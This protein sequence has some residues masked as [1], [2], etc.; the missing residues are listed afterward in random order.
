MSDAAP[1]AS[2]DVPD[3]DAPSV[4][5][6]GLHAGPREETVARN[7]RRFYAGLAL[8]LTLHSLMFAGFYSSPPRFIGDPSG[9]PDAISV[10]LVTDAEL[11]DLAATPD[12][13]PQGSPIPPVPTPQPPAEAT[14]PPA[15]VTPPPS[16]PQSAPA[17]ATPEPS[18]PSEVAVTDDALTLKPIEDLLASTQKKSEPAPAEPPRAPAPPAK[19]AKPERQRSAVLDLSPPANFSTFGGR[20]TNMARPAGITRSGENDFFARAVVSALQRTMPQLNETRGRVTVRITLDMDGDLVSTQVVNPSAIAGLD[21]SV[22]FATRQTSFPFPPR[23]ARTA[24]L[25]FLITYIY[26]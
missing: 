10:A 14:P 2:A 20:S 18:S 11:R 19:Q 13:K 9:S 25:V 1:L 17:K 21:R 5:L 3:A 22:V 12:P 23:N 4:A 15:E 16:P 24:D 7:D 6:A 26:N 8:A